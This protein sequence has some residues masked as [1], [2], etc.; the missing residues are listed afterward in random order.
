MFLFSHAGWTLYISRDMFR[1]YKSALTCFCLAM[2]DGHWEFLE[3]C[4]CIYSGFDAV[5]Y[6][7]IIFLHM[8]F[9]VVVSLFFIIINIQCQGS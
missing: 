2:P 5:Y 8:N 3:I 6:I 1:V 9:G 7:V 4:I